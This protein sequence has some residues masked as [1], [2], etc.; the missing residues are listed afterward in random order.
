MAIT[1]LPSVPLRS[2]VPNIFIS[3]A[4]AFMA[5]LPKFQ[6]EAN[7]MAEAMS[8]NAVNATSSTS[9]TIGV[10]NK[11][12]TVQAAKSYVPGMTVKIASTAAGD[13]W[14]LGDV[15]AYDAGT[16]ELEVEVSAINGAGTVADWTVSQSAPGG[17]ALNGS[18]DQNFS[19]RNLYQSLGADVASAATIDLDAATGDAVNITG[20]T[21]ITAI[22]L[23]AGRVKRVYHAGS[24]V[25]THSASLKLP[26]F[27]NIVPNIGDNSV[28]IGLPS[29]V[30]RCLAYRR[31]SGNDDVGVIK[32]FAGDIVPAGY[33]AC[34]TA[35][36][37]VLR[38]DYPALFAAIGTAWNGGGTPGDSFGLPYFEVGEVPL[39]GG[40]VGAATVGEVIAHLHTYTHEYGTSGPGAAGPGIPVSQAATNT[41]TTGG[42]KNLA[43]GRYVKFC[44]KY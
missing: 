40:T 20:S 23:G 15:L 37:D 32:A 19:V 34:P 3:K 42:A 10:G 44:I 33:L 38:A 43:A 29:G 16:G 5:A 22:T 11:V 14:M 4:D 21:T 28:W 18:V 12:L 2:D 30:V 1:P 7:A 17:A 8:L 31:A 9:L 24:H 27:A 35:Q 26:G 39:Q 6:E 25:L 36:T 13:N 41:S